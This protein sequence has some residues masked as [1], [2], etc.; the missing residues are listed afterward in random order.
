M[1]YGNVYTA[2]VS[3][4]TSLQEDMYNPQQYIAML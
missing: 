3:P 1:K 4:S 2:I